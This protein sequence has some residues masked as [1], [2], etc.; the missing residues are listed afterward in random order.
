MTRGRAPD[1]TPCCCLE[2]GRDQVGAIAMRCSGNDIMA[3]GT[4]IAAKVS[5]NR[6]QRMGIDDTGYGKDAKYGNDSGRANITTRGT[7]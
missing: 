2:D 7:R 1:V 3:K 6:K 5:G 4:C